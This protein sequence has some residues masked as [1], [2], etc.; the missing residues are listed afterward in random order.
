MNTQRQRGSYITSL[1]DLKNKL[2]MFREKNEMKVFSGI[3]LRLMLIS[4]YG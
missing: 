1:V 4:V 3:V 2:S